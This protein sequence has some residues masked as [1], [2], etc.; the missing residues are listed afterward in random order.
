MVL[1]SDGRMFW[2]VSV[3]GG[4]TS[5]IEVVESAA[6][7]VFAPAPA[8]AVSVVAKVGVCVTPLWSTMTVV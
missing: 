2:E 4:A 1:L 6:S 3:V 8:S 5:E 7:S